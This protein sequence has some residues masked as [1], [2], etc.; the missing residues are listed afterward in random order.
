[1]P[2]CLQCGIHFPIR[3]RVTNKIR[4]MH[5]RKYCLNCSP[6][7]QHN[8]KKLHQFPNKVG[9]ECERCHK[10]YDYRKSKGHTLK[11][12][13]SCM[14]NRRKRS[15][16]VWA[17]AY[18]GGSCISCGYDRCVQAMDFHHIDA[19]T[20]EFTIG[21]NLSF[22]KEKLRIELDKC[23]LLCSNCHREHHEGMLKLESFTSRSSSVVRTSPW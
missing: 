8:T 20:K 5:R 11:L 17:T 9:I 6:Y 2:D 1:M 21:G 19:N 4:F 12:C 10:I 13:N 16:K 18:K 22:S 15:L 3:I 7:G 23:V 14:V